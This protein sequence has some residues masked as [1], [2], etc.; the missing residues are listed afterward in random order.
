MI[1]KA[2]ENIS[3]GNEG[4]HKDDKTLV[5]NLFEQLRGGNPHLVKDKQKFDLLE[6]QILVSNID[7]LYHS[8]LYKF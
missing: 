3:S 5:K 2:L 1:L 6:D 4:K 8:Q 7:I